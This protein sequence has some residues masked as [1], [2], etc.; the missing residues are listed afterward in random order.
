[1]SPGR[2]R[3]R[4]RGMIMGAAISSSRAKKAA[5]SQQAQSTLQPT[6]QEDPSI[7]QL[8]QLAELKDQGILTQEEF[9][10]KKRQIL[11]I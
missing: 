2:A 5:A 9:D 10:T 11:G 6:T 8:K 7:A 3:S 1:M 4:R